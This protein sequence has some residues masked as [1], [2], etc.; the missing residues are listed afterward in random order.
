MAAKSKNKGKGF[1]REISKFLTD[2]YS[3]PF[4]RVFGSGA[5][6]GGKNFI[7]KENLTENQ[8][9]SHKGDIVPPDDW[10]RFNCECKNY[11]SFAFHLLLHNKPM[12]LLDQWITQTLAA[13]DIGDMNAIFMKFDR[14][15][16]Y[17]AVDPVHGFKFH[18]K[19]IY[20]SADG[21]LWYITEL[22]S[23]FE[24]NQNLFKKS[25]QL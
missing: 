7:R 1:E 3:E 21:S 4:Q 18:N 8:I 25:S 11:A 6:T 22:N 19:I 2:L 12:P 13:S 20:H 14:I 16:R 5:F 10:V 23:F 17:I 15:G 9:R 24:L